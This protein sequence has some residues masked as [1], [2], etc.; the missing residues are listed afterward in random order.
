MGPHI[1]NDVLVMIPASFI[2][3]KGPRANLT[4]RN[5]PWGWVWMVQIIGIVTN[6]CLCLGMAFL[7]LLIDTNYIIYP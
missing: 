5:A 1:I 4:P 2:D 6:H 7:K 3:P